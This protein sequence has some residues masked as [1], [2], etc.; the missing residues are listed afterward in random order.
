MASA[1]VC[2]GLSVGVCWAAWVCAA[3]LFCSD[4]G[5]PTALSVLAWLALLTLSL[6]LSLTAPVLGTLPGSLWTLT[7]VSLLSWPLWLFHCVVR[8]P[9]P[10]ARSD[11]SNHTV[12]L[13]PLY[14]A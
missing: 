12:S 8:A 10:P 6:S 1:A 2:A 5:L 3:C 7:L 4:S 9:L 11:L 14:S 13:V